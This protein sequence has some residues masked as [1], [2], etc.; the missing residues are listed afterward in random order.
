M[1]QSSSGSGVL[2]HPLAATFVLLLDWA[3]GLGEVVA[4]F[5]TMGLG[6]PAVM[7]TAGV[8]GLIGVTLIQMFLNGDGFGAAISKGFFAGVTCAIPTPIAGTVFGAVFLG[9]AILGPKQVN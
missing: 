4:L 3:A 5:T 6:L 7:L 9:Q 2:Y 8:L 1:S